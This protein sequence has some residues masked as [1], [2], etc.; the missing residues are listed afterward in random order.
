MFS[1]PMIA[2]FFGQCPNVPPAHCP[3]VNGKPCSYFCVAYLVFP[4]SLLIASAPIAPGTSQSRAGKRRP[5]KSTESSPG[6]LCTT[7]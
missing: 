2:T 5:G 7:L 4:F 6:T 3:V 1:S